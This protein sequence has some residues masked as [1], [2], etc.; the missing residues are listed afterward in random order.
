MATEDK[1]YGWLGVD[2]PRDIALRMAIL[3]RMIKKEDLYE[4]KSGF[5]LEKHPHVTV[6]YGHEENDPQSTREAIADL[7]AGEGKLGSISVFDT[8]PDYKV[9]KFD[10]DSPDLH[11]LNQRIRERIKLPGLTFNEYNPHVTVAYLKKHVDPAKYEKLAALLAG[12]KFPIKMIRWSNPANQYRTLLMPGVVGTPRTL[13]KQAS[14]VKYRI[15]PGSTRYKPQDGEIVSMPSFRALATVDGK[16]VGIAEILRNFHGK[17]LFR[18]FKVNKD[19]RGKGVGTELLR[20]LFEHADK[21]GIDMLHTRANPYEDEPM[22]REQLMKLYAKFGFEPTNEEG[23]ELPGGG[24]PVGKGPGAMIRKK[25]DSSGGP[26][27]LGGMADKWKDREHIREALRQHLI[28]AGAALGT[29]AEEKEMTDLGLITEAYGGT[30]NPDDAAAL[31]RDRLKKFLQYADRPSLAKTAQIIL[32]IEK[33]D[34]VLVGRFKNKEVTVESIGTDENGQPTINGRKL[35]S[36]RIKKLMP[37]GGP[38]AATTSAAAKTL[39]KTAED[40]W[41]ALRKNAELNKQGNVLT[42]LMKG[43]QERVQSDYSKRERDYGASV[44]PE[45]Y[46]GLSMPENFKSDLKKDI[47]KIKAIVNGMGS[48]RT[49][50]YSLHPDTMYGMDLT[51]VSDIHDYEY[52]YPSK[53]FATE[54]E[55]MAYRDAADQRFKE[56]ILK[57]VERHSS[58]ATREAGIDE[59]RKAMAEDYYRLL[60]M[61]GP[62]TF[63]KIHPIGQAAEPLQK[64]AMEKIDIPRHMYPVVKKLMEARKYAA[65]LPS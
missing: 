20:R 62:K 63:L 25:A 11:S 40:K 61:A 59:K 43:I 14:D 3:Q 49:W 21:E 52:T 44:S 10:V 60:R 51:P 16:Q 8:N 57:L 9:L 53:P 42:T 17:D 34:K 37:E 65:Q 22:T 56:N 58:K 4:D 35:L 7:M 27:N 54:E 38:V 31:R 64:A 1:S 19:Q 23:D 47:D 45:K 5:G 13:T 48:P 55:A 15:R 26:E 12:R 39:E 2:M 36:L 18:S 50:W 33:G 6:A 30:M 46:H 24:W 32:D 28:D 29:A 41:E